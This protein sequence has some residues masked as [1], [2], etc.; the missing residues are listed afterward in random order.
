MLLPDSRAGGSA[1]SGRSPWKD[2]ALFEYCGEGPI[3]PMVGIRRGTYKYVR[4]HG[5]RPLMFDLRND[6]HERTNLG[7][8][9]DHAPAETAQPRESEP[10]RQAPAPRNSCRRSE[11]AP[12]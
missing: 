11:G 7:G 12:L 9:P 1:V 6:P 3:E 4:A 5:Y 2:E 8:S 10:D